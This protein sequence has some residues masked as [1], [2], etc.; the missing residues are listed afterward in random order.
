TNRL[1]DILLHNRTASKQDVG[2]FVDIVSI[3]K[4]SSW[5]SIRGLM[6]LIDAALSAS[7]LGQYKHA[8][9]SNSWNSMIIPW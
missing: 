6:A 7:S 2:L 3:D 1:G 9:F 8:L 4:N 5:V